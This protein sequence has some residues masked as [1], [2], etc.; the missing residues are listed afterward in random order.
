MLIDF[1][2]LDES[3]FSEEKGGDWSDMV[4]EEVQN[5]HIHCWEE[6]MDRVTLQEEIR[7]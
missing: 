1:G 7:K 3:A 4:S 6:E 2:V 5:I